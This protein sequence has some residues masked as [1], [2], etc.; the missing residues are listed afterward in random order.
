[1]AVKKNLK[2][3]DRGKR[4]KS[5]LALLILGIFIILLSWVVYS[6]YIAYHNDQEQIRRLESVQGDLRYSYQVLTNTLPDLRYENFIKSCYESSADFGGQ[7]RCGV[8]FTLIEESVTSQNLPKL[9][10][11]FLGHFTH[12]QKFE[13]ISA[14]YDNYDETTRA[15]YAGIK[16]RHRSTV[17]CDVST[18]YYQTLSAY[19]HRYRTNKSYKDGILLMDV[20]CDESVSRFLPDYPV[21]M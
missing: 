16:I 19:N 7:K 6:K 11:V 14:R 9:Q 17:E 3:K 10:E 5:F 15:V 18:E 20:T 13:G 12:A 8:N 2:I 1:M 4:C 21:D